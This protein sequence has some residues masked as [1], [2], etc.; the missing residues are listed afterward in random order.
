MPPAH[1]RAVTKR[2][3][4]ALLPAEA[5]GIEADCF[6]VVDLLRATTT[7]ATLLG[8]GAGAVTVASELGAARALAA[9]RGALLYGE[10]G[11]LPPEGFDGGNSPVEARDAPV[12]GREVVLYT[13]N[14]T[15][16]LCALATRG[17]VATGALAN[18][19]A[20]ARFAASHERVCVVCAGEAR[21]MR[22]ALEDFAAAGGIIR[23]LVAL[24]PGAEMGDAAGL[25][26]ETARYDD[27][28][29]A[30]LP[31]Q[32]AASARLIAG[33]E[34]GQALARLGIAADVSF[35]V[36]EDTTGAVPL[37]MECGDGW[38]TLRAWRPGG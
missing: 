10:V 29:R 23:R 32:T 31:Q 26:I 8:A 16:A 6:I 38:A 28:L 15:R 13:T 20:V 35:C 30:G 14:G 17:A 3:E 37:V 11:G 27:W 5:A 9:H 4:L 21:G 2:I 25:A 18:A 36:E 33:S 34:H 7:I 22:F 24:A 12:A 1:A 19:S